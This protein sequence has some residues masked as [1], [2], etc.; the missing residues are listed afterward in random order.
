MEQYKRVDTPGGSG[1]DT[2]NTAPVT[3]DASKP[4]QNAIEERAKGASRDEI[5]K[6]PRT[7]H[8]F[9]SSGTA[10]DNRLG[11]RESLI[12]VKPPLSVIL[13]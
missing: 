6:Y 4:A 11:E 9:G 3:Y 7:P 1:G 10:D 12:V 5:V 13:R 2:S 8:L